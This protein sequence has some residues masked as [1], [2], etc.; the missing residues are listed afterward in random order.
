VSAGCHRYKAF[1][2]K[3]NML[4]M[5]QNESFKGNAKWVYTV[6]RRALNKIIS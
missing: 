4:E 2:K 1:R 5:E 3:N 6:Q